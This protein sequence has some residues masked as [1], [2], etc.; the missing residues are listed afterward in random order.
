MLLLEND[1]LRLLAGSVGPSV[2]RQPV[3]DDLRGW[4]W[5]RPPL[6]P[7]FDAPLSI[8]EVA[9]GVCPTG[10]DVYLT[11]V[12]GV[13][14]RPTPASLA[15]SALRS[16]V[17]AA[18]VAAKRALYSEGLPAAARL[19]ETAPPPL[20]EL[21]GVEAP[22]PAGLADQVSALWAW[23]GRRLGARLA[24]T[25]AAAPGAGSDG[26][27][28]VALPVVVG[29]PL[30]GRFL[31]LTE[32]LTVEHALGPLPLVHVLRFGEPRPEDRLLIAG[33]A[34]ALEAATEA[35]L[36]Y[37][38]LSYGG[39]QGGQP[40]VRRDLHAIDDEARQLFIETRDEKAR[41]VQEEID[42]G[43]PAVCPDDCPFWSV[44]H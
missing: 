38:C 27:L 5:Y 37:G 33:R 32:R 19:A 10:R 28:A 24:D 12:L 31:G 1:D 35:A 18:L 20:A 7:V 44:C 36:D 40:T 17:L 26:L 41:L 22:A 9:G 43:L 21:L 3:A 25:A 6:S 14:P 11:H 42:P 15:E 39:F 2:R 8:E 16:T 30:D 23:E 34:L 13:P 29:R 4:H